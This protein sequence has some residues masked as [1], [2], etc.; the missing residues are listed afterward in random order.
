M[1]PRFYFS[2]RVG[3]ILGGGECGGA[4]EIIRKFI[5][6]SRT[7]LETLYRF[8]HFYLYNDICY[9]ILSYFMIFHII[10]TYIL[11]YQLK[12]RYSTFYRTVSARVVSFE[13]SCCIACVRLMGISGF[14]FLPELVS[15][16]V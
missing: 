15:V 2:T 9:L 3:R 5:L 4:T 16:C 10:F 11:Y 7:S 12:G 8:G 6:F 1:S 13:R 14:T